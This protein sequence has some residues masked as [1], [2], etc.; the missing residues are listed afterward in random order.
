LR[1]LFV[2]FFRLYFAVRPEMMVFDPLVKLYFKLRLFLQDLFYFVR[3][4][5]I[6]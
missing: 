4:F 5:I 1:Y 2:S 6:N 3:L